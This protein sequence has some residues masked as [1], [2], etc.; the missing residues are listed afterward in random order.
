MVRAG[1]SFFDRVALLVNL[2]ELAER[3]WARFG[4]RLPLGV[5]GALANG[6]AHLVE[7]RLRLALVWTSRLADVGKHTRTPR[8]LPHHACSQRSR[9]RPLCS[10]IL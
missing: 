1:E 6:G 5:E 3:H 7:H 2:G 9:T 4:R 10:Q 8:K